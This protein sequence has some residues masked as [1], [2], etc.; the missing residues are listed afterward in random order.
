MLWSTPYSEAQEHA[1]ELVRLERLRALGEMAAGIS[2]NLNNILTTIMGPARSSS[3]ALLAPWHASPAA[4]DAR[5]CGAPRP[6]RSSSENAPPPRAGRSNPRRSTLSPLRIVARDSTLLG[7]LPAA[8]HRGGARATRILK[9]F[10][11]DGDPTISEAAQEAL[12][13]L[14]AD[15]AGFS[16]TQLPTE[17]GEEDSDDD[18]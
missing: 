5:T 1:R 16:M 18:L 4:L 6:P 13:I 11:A 15:D 3:A 17:S 10:A 14:T 7:A 8:P 2:H 9:G 12:D